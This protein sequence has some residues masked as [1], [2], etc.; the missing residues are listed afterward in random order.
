M[1]LGFYQKSFLIT[2]DITVADDGIFGI[3]PAAENAVNT[4]TLPRASGRVGNQLYLQNLSLY[5]QKVAAASGDSVFGGALLLPGQLIRY[6]SDG[7]DWYAFG[8]NGVSAVASVVLSSANI[9]AMNGAPVTLI[10][11]PGAG[12]V[13]VVEDID[14]Q[15][16][17]TA[18]AYANGGAVEFRYTDGSGAKVSADIAAAVITG[19]AGTAYAKVLG[20]EASLVVVPNAPLV[21]TNA[22]AAFITGTGAG[23]FRIKYRIDDF[24]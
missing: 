2:T 10:P 17:R 24:N 7:S 6:D 22:T 1:S 18:T 4:I 12:R 23:K 14:F 11:A 19:A 16:V 21:V 9:L 20:L 15:I 3:V 5:V 13:I 8:A